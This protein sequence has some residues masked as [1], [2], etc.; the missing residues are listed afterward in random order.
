MANMLVCLARLLSSPETL[1]DTPRC[2]EVYDEASICQRLGMGHI[3]S[4]GARASVLGNLAIGTQ[5]DHIPVM[6]RK[7]RANLL[8]KFSGFV[9]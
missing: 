6:N 9:Q 8:H 1:D 3:A 4:L 2:D 7:A 5:E